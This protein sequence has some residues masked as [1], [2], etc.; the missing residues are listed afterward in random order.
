MADD[1]EIHFGDLIN[2]SM[3]MKKCGWKQFHLI[4]TEETVVPIDG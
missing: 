4:V 2:I 3:A 1:D